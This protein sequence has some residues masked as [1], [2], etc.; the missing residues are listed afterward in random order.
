MPFSTRVGAV[1]PLAP[2]TPK[3]HGRE[4]VKAYATMI[5]DLSNMRNSLLCVF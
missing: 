3:V 1:T 2:L 4:I 5:W